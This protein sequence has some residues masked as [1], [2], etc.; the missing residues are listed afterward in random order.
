MHQAIGYGLDIAN[1]NKSVLEDFSQMEDDARR[2]RFIEEV[3][4]YA[5]VHDDLRERM[6]FHPNTIA[7]LKGGTPDLYEMARYDSEFGDPDKLLLIPFGYHDEWHRYGDLLDVFAYETY[8]HPG[9]EGFME[10]EFRDKPGTLYP[11]VG[12]MRAN[13]EKPL[14]VEDYWETCYLDREEHKHAIP[15]A[16]RHIWFLIKHLELVPE[17]KITETFLKLRPTLYRWFS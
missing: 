12:L 4:A 2:D 11:F 13:P 5:E 9:E 8:R 16:P 14:G 17:P 10:P 1:M 3:R 7:Q 15:T 6:M